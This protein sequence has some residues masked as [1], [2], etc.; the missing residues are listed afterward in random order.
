MSIQF[1]ILSSNKSI[2]RNQEYILIDIAQ[3]DPYKAKSYRPG[4]KKNAFSFALQFCKSSLV[5]NKI[6]ARNVHF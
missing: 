5:P 4:G 2:S 1:I 6:Q 3:H